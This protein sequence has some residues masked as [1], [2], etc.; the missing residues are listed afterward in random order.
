[1]SLLEE[2]RA[3]A[4]AQVLGQEPS[5][6]YRPMTYLLG[7]GGKAMRPLLLMQACQAFGLRPRQAALPAAYAIEL[8]HNFSLM[9][10]DIMDESKLRRGQ[11]TVHKVYDVN[12]ALL[13]GDAMLVL[14]YH[15]LARVP[16]D[17][18]PTC[19]KHFNQVA[20][21]VCE[22]Q[23]LDM[24][25]EQPE[26]WPNAEAYLEM[27]RLKTAVLP[28]TALVLGAILGGASPDEAKLLGQFGLHLGLAFQLQ[29]DWLDTFGQEAEVGKRIGGDILQG[30]KTILPIYTL[31]QA[32]DEDRETLLAYY[33][34]KPE[35]EKA[36]ERK[37]R[38]VTKLFKK[39]QA[40]KALK[41]LAKSEAEAARLALEQV[42]ITEA[43]KAVFLTYL[44]QLLERKA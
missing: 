39:Y 30:K 20:L 17:L 27:I 13:S 35:G 42:P 16:A 26:V 29:D 37:I 38:E 25:F 40:D 11:P 6:L 31:A 10:D 32:S 28:Q 34:E 15:Y 12:T 4:A 9:H 22:G 33:R 41:G 5:R 19:L 8:F 7:L 36:E 23:R 44:A 18:L 2:Y 3:Y 43:E 14:A 24:D 1:M 21:E